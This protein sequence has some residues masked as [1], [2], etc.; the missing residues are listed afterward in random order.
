MKRLMRLTRHAIEGREVE[1][2]GDEEQRD[3]HGFEALSSDQRMPLSGVTTQ[4]HKRGGVAC[5][6]LSSVIAHRP[7]QVV[8]RIRIRRLAGWRSK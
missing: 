5:Q 2:A 7:E 4:A 3:S 1:L 8:R 6:W